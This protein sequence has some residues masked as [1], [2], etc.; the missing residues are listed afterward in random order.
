MDLDEIEDLLFILAYSRHREHR[1]IQTGQPGQD[2]IK[3]LLDSAH[4]ERIHQVLRMQVATFYTLRD[5]LVAN[6]DLKGDNII[7]NR[8]RRGHGMQV[9]IEE[10]LVIF[11]YISSRGAS[12]RDASSRN[13]PSNC[14]LLPYPII[15]APRQALFM[16]CTVLALCLAFL[17]IRTHSQ[18]PIPALVILN[19]Y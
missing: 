16:F 18:C 6:T 7:H 4:P 2:Y 9:S 13:L 11:I 15:P 19:Q 5:W 10:K 1:R 12:H 17:Y 8:R 3:E 14:T